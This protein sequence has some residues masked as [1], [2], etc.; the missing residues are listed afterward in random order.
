MNTLLTQIEGLLNSRPLFAH[1]SDL[2]EPLALTPAHFLL[3]LTP[4]TKLPANDLTAININR[5]DRYQII[6]RMVQDFW[7]RWHA[8]Y[9]HNLQIRETW[10]TLHRIIIPL[11]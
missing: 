9:L 6:D 3:T 11:K 1:S 7:K 8:E 2:S 5:L 4:L 10:N